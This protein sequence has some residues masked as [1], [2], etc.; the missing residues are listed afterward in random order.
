MAA[1]L[2][3]TCWQIR[4][5]SKSLH[6]FTTSLDILPLGRAFVQP[7]P[8]GGNRPIWVRRLNF[9]SLDIH[10]NALLLLHDMGLLWEQWSKPGLA[11]V[12]QWRERYRTSVE[13][14]LTVDSKRRGQLAKEHQHLWT[15]SKEVATEMWKAVLKRAW[16]N[17][18]MV[19]QAS[20]ADAKA[21]D[22]GRQAAPAS[23]PLMHIAGEPKSVADLAEAFVAL[24]YSQFLL[25]AV[26]QIQNLL[27]FP[28]IGFVL[29]MLAMNSYSFQAPHLIGR[30][31]LIL[32]RV[33]AWILG[34]CMVRSRAR[35][36]F[37][38]YC[39][40]E[41]PGE[42]GV[43]FYLKLARYGALPL[44]GLLAWQFPWISNFLMSWVEPALEALQ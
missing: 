14:A 12:G 41:S 7:S 20:N 4:M 42:L 38:P 5:M 40:H 21:E 16:G 32:C 24:H 15:V 6:G 33:I 23:K 29:L 34:T 9:Q 31:L 43:T 17:Q 44:V 28:S 26:R 13:S 27:W 18:A 25:Y 36:D 2:L 10:R 22:E 11:Q 30:F 8:A 3:L 35:S 37:E 39:G 19:G 1:L